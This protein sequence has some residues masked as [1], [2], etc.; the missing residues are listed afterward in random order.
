MVHERDPDPLLETAQRQ[1]D[2]RVGDAEALARRAESFRL[3]DRD[4][5]RH[6]IELVRH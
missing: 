2:R 1:T 5:C 4:E 3:R 6:A